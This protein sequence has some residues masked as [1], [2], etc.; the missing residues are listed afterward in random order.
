M[1]DT[2]NLAPIKISIRP[3]PDTR[4]IGMTYGDYDRAR[5]RAVRIYAWANGETILSWLTNRHNARAGVT[6][7]KRDIV[8]AVL[9]K[10]GLPPDTKVRWSQKAGCACGCSPGFILPEYHGRDV[11]VDYGTVDDAAR[12]SVEG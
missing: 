9:A 2:I 3:V 12:A 10:M 8:P 4:P 11:F 1:T 6:E 7:L 5:N